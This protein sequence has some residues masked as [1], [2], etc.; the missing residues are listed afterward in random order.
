MKNYNNFLGDPFNYPTPQK[1][2][3]M[4]L[5]SLSKNDGFKIKTNDF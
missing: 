2:D 3:L 1:K 5:S 4:Y